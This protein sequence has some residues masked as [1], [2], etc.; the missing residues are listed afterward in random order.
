MKVLLFTLLR[1]FEFEM[2]VPVESF[3]KRSFVVSRPYLK[4]DSKAG[5]QMP[6]IVV[7]S[8]WKQEEVID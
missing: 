2:F 8:I 1:N 4:N 6:L 5:A 3:E 7:K